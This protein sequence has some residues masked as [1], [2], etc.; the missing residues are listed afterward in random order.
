[1][2]FCMQNHQS[3]PFFHAHN[4]GRLNPQE[5]H[6]QR[7]LQHCTGQYYANPFT[8]NPQIQPATQPIPRGQFPLIT[9]LLV[10]KTPKQRKIIPKI[11]SLQIK[12]KLFKAKKDVAHPVPPSQNTPTKP[13]IVLPPRKKKQQMFATILA[14][15]PQK[16]LAKMAKEKKIQEQYNIEEEHYYLQKTSQEKTPEE[17]PAKSFSK[18]KQKKNDLEISLEDLDEEDF[19]LLE[20]LL[21]QEKNDTKNLLTDTLQEK[22]YNRK[23]KNTYQKYLAEEYGKF[24]YENGFFTCPFCQAKENTGEALLNHIY[25]KCAPDFDYY[26][27]NQR[28]LAYDKAYNPNAQE[29][30][31]E[32]EFAIETPTGNQAPPFTDKKTFDKDESSSSED[33]ESSSSDEDED[34]ESSSNEEEEEEEAL[35]HK[36]RGKTPKKIFAGHRRKHKKDDSYTYNGKYAKYITVYECNYKRSDKNSWKCNTCHKIFECYPRSAGAHLRSQHGITAKNQQDQEEAEDSDS[37]SEE[38][39]SETEKER[40]YTTPRRTG[41]KKRKREDCGKY[42]GKYADYIT[43]YEYNT[44]EKKHSWKCNICD[45]EYKSPPWIAGEHLEKHNIYL[46]DKQNN[47]PPKKKRK[48]HI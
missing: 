43:V 48:I 34:E 39:E 28:T 9:H 4:P 26:S 6:R 17:S 16:L 20:Q 45:K 23:K 36:P 14:E 11:K 1:M 2:V 15:S 42:T 25:K 13:F 30:L 18:S 31:D 8:N 41:S 47:Q 29:D 35:T 19:L 32:S 7:Q 21:P 40:S 5:L 33:E 12:H 3:T 24:N 22:P 27:F 44:R 38:S 46:M 10:Q 37:S